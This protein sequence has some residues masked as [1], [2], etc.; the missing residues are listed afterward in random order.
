VLAAIVDHGEDAV[1]EALEAALSAGTTQLRAL[2]PCRAFE[3]PAPVP[4][5]DTL[6]R[7]LVESGRAA[8]YDWLLAGGGA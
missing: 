4:V 1:S 5:P 3:A 8:D 7:H 2:A 6:A